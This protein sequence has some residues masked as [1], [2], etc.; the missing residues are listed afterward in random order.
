MPV[1]AQEMMVRY[2]GEGWT[3]TEI[4]SSYFLFLSRPDEPVDMAI[5]I[6]RTFVR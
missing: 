1:V 3:I 5:S 4:D 2:S 6:A